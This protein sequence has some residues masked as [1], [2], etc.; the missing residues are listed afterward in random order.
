M[1]VSII[2]PVY[3]PDGRLLKKILTIVKKQRFDGNI[4]LIC[5]EKGLGLAASLNYGIKKSKYPVI[6]SLHQDCLPVSENWLSSLII[7]LKKKKFVASCSDVYDV[8][9]GIR[10]TPLLDEKGCAY[11]K[12]ALKRAS[13]FDE[14]HFLNSGEDMD[15]YLKL[16]RIG[17]IF[18]P[19]C[20]VE[21]Y[22]QGYLKK[23]TARK[24]LQNANTSGCLFRKW[25]F[26]LPGWWKSILMANP[27]NPMYCWYYWKGFVK[28][29]QDFGR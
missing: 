18:Y 14:T 26:K 28:K 15:M 25:G 5:V 21:H 10:Y 6:I 12:E 13:F 2:I 8:E 9:T 3:N 7:P 27:L 17:K 29:K 22:H 1:N 20:I 23:K 11:K 24:I 4:E 19:H 16:G